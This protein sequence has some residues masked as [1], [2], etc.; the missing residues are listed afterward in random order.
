MCSIAASETKEYPL[1]ANITTDGESREYASDFLGNV[2]YSRLDAHSVAPGEVTL[3]ALTI[4][5]CA[6]ISNFTLNG[7]T[8]TVET[9]K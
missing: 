5:E 9:S 3:D 7:V 6:S 4:T 8:Y 2:I 1:V